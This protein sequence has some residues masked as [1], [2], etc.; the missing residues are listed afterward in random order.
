MPG[1][2]FFGVVD[3]RSGSLE[4]DRIHLINPESLVVSGNSVLT[5]A[6]VSTLPFLSH[7]AVVGD[8]E[9]HN[10]ADLAISTGLNSPRPA[11]WC[12]ADLLLAAYDKWGDKCAA[13]LLG[14]FSFAIWDKRLR[15]LFCCRDQVGIRPFLY[16]TQGPRFV[17]SSSPGPIL[18]FPGVDRRP[19]LDRIAVMAVRG[20]RNYVHRET[21]HQGVFSLPFGS[22][23]GFDSAGLRESRYWQPGTGSVPIPRRE[24]EIVDAFR[25]LVFESVRC[26]MQQAN[27]PAALLSGGLDSSSVVAV[28]ARS[29]WTAEKPLSV[30]AG[31]L[32]ADAPPEL[33]DEREFIDQFLSWKNLRIDYVAPLAD[34]GPF[35]GLRDPARF[36]DTPLRSPAD[37]FH[38]AL[39]EFALSRGIAE[40][41]VGSGGELGASAWSRRS[42]LQM[43]VQFRWF[44]LARELS[45]LRS[46]S[47][48]HPV[49]VLGGEILRF[50]NPRREMHPMV[51]LREGLRPQ[52]GS[53]SFPT[54]SL[55]VSGY[56]EAVLRYWLD[57]HSSRPA[58]FGLGLIRYVDP[59]L[60]RRILEFCLRVPVQL[61]V[62]NGYQRYLLRAA[63]DGILPKKIQWRT[64]KVPFSPDYGFR[65][66]RQL[67][68]AQAFVDSISARDPIRSLVDIP[69]LRGLLRPVDPLARDRR[70]FSLVPNTLNLICFLRQ[71]PEFCP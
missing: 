25:D 24:G 61:K 16:W 58:R 40:F 34:Q 65:F 30:L 19:N 56:E 32:P 3:V 47:R 33:K 12:D 50:L 8:I 43:A 2:S 15:R 26:R 63:L 22:C 57:K 11:P 70:A 41:F 39:E 42:Y 10:K 45:A 35:D 66:N 71:F 64:D 13:R 23:I 17:F 31:V 36:A 59:L 60:D 4:N 53:A 9:L 18:A 68:A 48:L 5:G 14:E 54:R 6:S 20:P 51:L 62:R 69:G 7:L 38:V 52:R 55:L 27:S 67:G 1:K 21:F 37:Y 29:A 44:R 49:R 28:A 46:N